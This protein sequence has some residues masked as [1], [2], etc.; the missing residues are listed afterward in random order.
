MLWQLIQLISVVKAVVL[1]YKVIED[2]GGLLGALH[3]FNFVIKVVG[4]R[5]DLLLLERLERLNVDAAH[6]T[7]DFKATIAVI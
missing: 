5:C 2:V 1:Q 3:C 6:A 4:V 7:A